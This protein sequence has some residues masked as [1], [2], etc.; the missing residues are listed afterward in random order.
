MLFSVTLILTAYSFLTRTDFN[1][2]GR[3]YVIGVFKNL[4][5]NIKYI[6]NY[7]ILI[8]LDCNSDLWNLLFSK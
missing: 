1:N 3:W 2:V 4:I 7:F 8:F 6:K 5:L